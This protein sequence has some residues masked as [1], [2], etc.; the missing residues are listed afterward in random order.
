MTPEISQ[1]IAGGVVG[2]ATSI[3]GFLVL[4]AVGKV[5]SKVDKVID[6]QGQHATTLAVVQSQVTR[7]ESDLAALKG[8]IRGEI[9]GIRLLYND[10]AGFLQGRGF[11]KRDG[12]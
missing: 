12:L 6:T 1:V 4:R 9:S 10:L 5:D 11:K 3:V 7:N 8:E 2:L